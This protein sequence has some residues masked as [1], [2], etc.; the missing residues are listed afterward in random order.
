MLA[1]GQPGMTARAWTAPRA[2]RGVQF[3]HS[4]STS[5]RSARRSR[6][7]SETSCTRHTPSGAAAYLAPSHCPPRDALSTTLRCTRTILLSRYLTGGASERPS[8]VWMMG[9]RRI[10]GQRQGPR[11]LLSFEKKERNTVAHD[12]RCSHSSHRTSLLGS[13][14]PPARRYVVDEVLPTSHN[15]PGMQCNAAREKEGSEIQPESRGPPRGAGSPKSGCM[16]GWDDG[17]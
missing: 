17:L 4:G 13:T 12:H 3:G 11:H 16:C 9:A 15:C 8:K 7:S 10:G 1:A 5:R 14:K 2:H 6:I